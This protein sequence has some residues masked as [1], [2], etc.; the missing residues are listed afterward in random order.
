MS[1]YIVNL[2]QALKK[3]L[4]MIGPEH[5]INATIDINVIDI[6]YE[7][8]LEI[9][10]LI[11]YHCASYSVWH[12]SLLIVLYL[13]LPA[14]S[15]DTPALYTV[16]SNSSNRNNHQRSSVVIRNLK[17]RAPEDVIELCEDK[18]YWLVTLQGIKHVFCI[19]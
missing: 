7:S 17:T 3:F 5:R 6:I 10:T 11:T 4:I 12:G 14:K 19:V 18:S 2:L 16:C 8:E 13:A 1:V 15:M 9:H